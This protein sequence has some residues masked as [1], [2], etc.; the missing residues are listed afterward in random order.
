MESQSGMVVAK[1]WEEEDRAL[2]T[3]GHKVS[4]KQD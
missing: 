2:L 3:N 4:L 1:N